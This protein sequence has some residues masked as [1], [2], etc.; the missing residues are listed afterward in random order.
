ILADPRQEE[1]IVARQLVDEFPRR[2]QE[3]HGIPLKFTEP[4]ADLLVNEAL[5]RNESVRDLCANRFKDFQFGL[6]LITQNSGTNE[7]VIEI[8]TVQQPGKVLSDWVAASYRSI[9]Q[10]APQ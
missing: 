1:R 5:E 9:S 10:S 3:C 8:E 4:A 2:F 7:F 6:K